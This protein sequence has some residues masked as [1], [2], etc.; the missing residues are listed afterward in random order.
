MCKN[1]LYELHS[2]FNLK[3]IEFNANH[4]A[5][6]DDEIYAETEYTAISAGTEIAAWMGKTG[7]RPGST[8]PRLIG[9]CN[10]AKVI[11]M[12][13]HVKNLNLG[14]Y[15]LTH[16][17]HRTTFICKQKDILLQVV[18]ENE[19]VRKKMTVL[20]LY[21]LGYAALMTGNLRPGNQVAIIGMGTLGIATAALLKAFGMQPFI[22]TDQIV[23]KEWKN[24]MGFHFIFPKNANESD[25]KKE[26]Y[27]LDGADIVINTS[28]EWSDFLLSQQIARKGGKIICVGFPGRDKKSPTFNPL[29]SQYF[30]DKQLCIKHSGY[31]TD[32]EADAID[33]RFTLKRNM[34]YLASLVTLN[35]INPFDILSQEFKSENLQDAYDFIASRKH[36]QYSALIGWK[37]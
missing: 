9:Y 12:G 17:S 23:R 31:S 34:K 29:D 26:L 21:H 22:F 30:Y 8:Y 36:G 4:Y 13:S 1:Y 10:L 20:Y 27:D 14:D 35:L 6:N 2:P 25:F 18:D 3:K 19:D 24:K 33:V 15:I 28:D 5:L 37:I 16:Q 11:K 7:L 32:I